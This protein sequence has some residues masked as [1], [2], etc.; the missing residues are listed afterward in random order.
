[1]AD[2]AETLQNYVERY[3]RSLTHSDQVLMKNE[4]ICNDTDETLKLIIRNL[5]AF[6]SKVVFYSGFAEGTLVSCELQNEEELKRKG[7]FKSNN[8]MNEQTSCQVVEFKFLLASITIQ[9]LI[10]ITAL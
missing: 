6:N 4:A 2:T 5:S 9:G 10:N 1:M 3:T 8:L 7:R